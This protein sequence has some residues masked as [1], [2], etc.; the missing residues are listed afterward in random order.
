MATE[1]TSLPEVQRL[2]AAYR[3]SGC[4]HPRICRFTDAQFSWYRRALEL[5]GADSLSAC[6]PRCYPECALS[7]PL[8]LTLAALNDPYTASACIRSVI[9]LSTPRWFDRNGP[10][11]P[12]DS[13]MMMIL[14]FTLSTCLLENQLDLNPG[15]KTIDA[16]IM[17]LAG[18][19]CSR[20]VWLED[21][22][23]GTWSRLK[24]LNMSF[25]F[26]DRIPGSEGTVQGNRYSVE[27]HRF[28]AN[29]TENLQKNLPS[30]SAR[31]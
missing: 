15:E 1:S 23:A 20:R 2:N 5:S 4:T 9:L 14:I 27:K 6:F 7:A 12:A 30:Y 17:D 25:R 26:L 22:L 8:L 18:W 31:S 3:W 19:D 29:F 11:V 10:Y 16:Q 24:I 28:Q 13:F 21:A